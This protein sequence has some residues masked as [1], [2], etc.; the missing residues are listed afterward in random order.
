VT[1]RYQTAAS[2][3][4]KTVNNASLLQPYTKTQYGSMFVKNTGHSVLLLRTVPTALE[5]SVK[6]TNK[7]VRIAELC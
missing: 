5:S 4:E 7:L 2:V 3:N 6:S 1:T